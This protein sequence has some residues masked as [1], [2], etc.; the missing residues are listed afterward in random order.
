M[1]VSFGFL[2]LLSEKPLVCITQFCKHFSPKSLD[3]DVR[4]QK[5]QYHDLDNSRFSLRKLHELTLETHGE[6]SP[7]ELRMGILKHYYGAL[8]TA[9][10]FRGRC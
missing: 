4:N 1:N 9:L 10:D 8:G 7:D 5:R 2:A 6:G 3:F